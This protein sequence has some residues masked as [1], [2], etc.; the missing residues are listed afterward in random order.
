[1][2]LP[3]QA[4]FK[5]LAYSLGP[6]RWYQPAYR[7]IVADIDQRSGAWLDIGCGTG[8]LC[9]HAAAGNPLLD[10]IGIDICEEMLGAA[11]D[12]KRGRLNFTIRKMNAENI[13]YP[14]ATFD[15]ITAIQSAHHWQNPAKILEEAKRVLVPGG[16]FF[17]Y[18]ADAESEIPEGWIA[19]KG[20]WPPEALLRRQWGK[21]GMDAG[22]WEK[23][24]AEAI[25][26]FGEDGVIDE[27]HGFYRR[28]VCSI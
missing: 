24:K 8:W 11:N 27:R 28:L 16:R 23:L 15:V 2:P 1:M 13:V 9:L 5:T 10:V 6:S 4:F 21:Y 18:E 26:V 17:I 3:S 12:N 25:A 20:G 7:F 14:K 19:K 22:A